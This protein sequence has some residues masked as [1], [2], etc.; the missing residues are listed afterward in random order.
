MSTYSG[1]KTFVENGETFIV[2]GAADKSNG[3][4]SLMIAEWNNG[5]KN[6]ADIPFDKV[7][8]ASNAIP[9]EI[10]VSRE[11]DGLYLYVVLNGNNSVQKIEWSSKKT[12]WTAATGVA[13]YGICVANNKIFVSNWAGEKA[14]DPTRERAGVPWGLAYTDPVTGATAGGS[15]TIINSTDGKTIAELQVGLHPNAVKASVDEKFI[16]VANGSSDNIAVINAMTNK[17]VESIDVG[18][19]RGKQSFAGSTPNGLELNAENSQLYVSNGLDNAVAVVQLG[20]NVSST[21]KENLW[22]WAISPQKPTLPD[23]N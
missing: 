4:S 20:K 14:T 19:M 2:W 23:L 22:C 7:S 18:L 6:I 11:K 3:K 13:P 17:L 21:G 1:I 16:Y 12:I 15:V 5:L 8:P 9:N 10:A